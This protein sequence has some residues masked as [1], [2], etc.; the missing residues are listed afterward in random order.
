MGAAAFLPAVALSGHRGTRSAMHTLPE[1]QLQPVLPDLSVSILE[2]GSCSQG[3]SRLEAVRH[4][5]VLEVHVGSGAGLELVGI[6][7]SS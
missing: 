5:R 3:L 2:C 1:E 6:G 4:L 7:W